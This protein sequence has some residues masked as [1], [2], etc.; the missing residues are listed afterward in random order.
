MLG[1]LLFGSIR[2]QGVLVPV[3]EG[4]REHARLMLR[5]Y[6]DDDN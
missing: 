3:R 6:D 2:R 4:R 5:Y 1:K